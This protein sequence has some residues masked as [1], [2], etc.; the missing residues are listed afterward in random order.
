MFVMSAVMF[1]G[2]GA[3]MIFWAVAQPILR[4]P[5]LAGAQNMSWSWRRCWPW[6]SALSLVC[7]RLL[8]RRQHDCLARVL[9][10]ADLAAV[11]TPAHL[12]A[13]LLSVAL[14]GGV[15][16]AGLLIVSGLDSAPWSGAVI[17]GLVAGACSVARLRTRIRRRHRNIERALPFVLDMMTLCVESGSSLYSALQQAEQH[18]PPG[19]LHDELVRAVVDMRTGVPRVAALRALADR[20]DCA[21]V[22]CWIAALIQ[23]DGCG[24]SIGALLREHAAQCRA[25]RFQLAE[26][27]A[28]QAPVKMLLPLIGCIFPCTFIVLAFPIV[29]QMG[30]IAP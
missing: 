28:M 26:K 19:P 21:S 30:A 15:F 9:Q 7:G 25:Q 22:T 10:R 23:A 20:C 4:S 1:A 2:A 29:M 6:L 12:V 13:R 17:G 27:M 16:A 11:V 5:G 18:G 3:T 24:M 14:L 8:S